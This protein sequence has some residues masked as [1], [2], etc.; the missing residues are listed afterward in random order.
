MFKIRGKGA[1]AFGAMLAVAASTISAAPA[2]AATEITFWGPTQASGG[3]NP[4]VTVTNAFNASQT[5]YKVTWVEKGAAGTYGT[6]LNTAAQAGALPDV[7]MTKPG[8]GD[9]NSLIPLAKAGLLAPLDG[10]PAA[11]TILPSERTT[12]LYKGKVYAA[13]FDVTPVGVTAN[14]TL[15]KKLGVTWPTSYSSMISLCKKLVTQDKT[16]F[17]LAG[18]AG[19]NTGLMTQLMAANTVYSKDPAWNVKREAKKVKFATSTEWKKTMNQVAEMTKAGCFQ[20]KAEAGSFGTINTLIASGAAIAA[21]VPGGTAVDWM[22]RDKVRYDVYPMPTGTTS[23][24]TRILNSVSYAASINKKTKNLAAA[25]AFVNYI[26]SPTGQ[27]VFTKVTGSL[28]NKWVFDP[29]AQP[30]FTPIASLIGQGKFVPQPNSSWSN[31]QVYTKLGSGIQG[32]LTGQA[33]VDAVLQSMDAA[34]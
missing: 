33:T 29:T 30:W 4:Y 34:W 27:A 26:S 10:T 7:F 18:A 17:V 1:L 15:M 3:V 24:D 14:T 32:L 5:K 8:I 25:K 13:A 28:T 2:S 20:E 21:F 19:P 9:L 12:M 16:L 31:A 11:S 23:A 6:A 22:K